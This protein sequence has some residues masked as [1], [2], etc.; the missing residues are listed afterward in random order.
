MIVVDDDPE[1]AKFI[2]SAARS[3]GFDVRAAANASEFKGLYDENQPSVILLDIVMPETDGIE[4]LEWLANRN[5]AVPIVM[6]S[7]YGGK[8]LNAAAQL[9]T[10]KGFTIIGTLAKPFRLNELQTVLEQVLEAWQR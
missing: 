4:L 3:M 1:I 5:S 6:I 8:Y 10:A 7:G 9:A 2:S